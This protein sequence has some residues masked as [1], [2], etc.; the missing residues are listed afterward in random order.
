M[1]APTPPAPTTRMRLTS[2]GSLQTADAVA[3]ELLQ[4]TEGVSV[5]VQTR[6]TS[7]FRADIQQ[8]CHC[9]NRFQ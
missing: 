1:L 4:A 2:G 8:Q 3:S 7:L 9:V 5:L 6:T